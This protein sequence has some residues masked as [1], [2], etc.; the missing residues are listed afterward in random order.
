MLTASREDPQGHASDLPPQSAQDGAI[1]EPSIR[2]A[3]GDR[4]SKGRRIKNRHPHRTGTVA[5]EANGELPSGND[6]RR[7]SD[8]GQNPSERIS[9]K[10]AAREPKAELARKRRAD[11]RELLPPPEVPM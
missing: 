2:E 8:G 7:E 11:S 3:N 6:A 1:R 10:V 4:H 9:Q 5:R